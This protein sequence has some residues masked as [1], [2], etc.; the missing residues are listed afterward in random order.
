M[1]PGFTSDRISLLVKGFGGASRDRTDDL[2]VANEEVRHFASVFMRVPQAN[3][4][5][6]GPIDVQS[7]RGELPQTFVA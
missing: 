6:F 4:G 7:A 3:Y 2:I 1:Q 5:P